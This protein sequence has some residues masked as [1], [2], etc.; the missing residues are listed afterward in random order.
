MKVENN[1]ILITGGASGIGLEFARQF[2]QLGNRVIVTGRNLQK[3][4]N[5]RKNFPQIHTF[6][7]D[8]TLAEDIRILFE[9]VTQRFPELN[10][11][12]NNAGIGRILDLKEQ[13]S[14]F[15]LTEELDTN[16]RA[17]IQM[18][19][20]FLPQ[21]KQQKDAAIINVSSALAFVPFPKV[22]IYSA[23]KAGLHSY[24]LSLRIQLKNTG[25]KVFEVAPPSTQT[26]MLDGL[27]KEI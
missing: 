1:T 23:A 11:L 7:S 5:V 18:I 4:E 17:P 19:N 12:I 16:L 13:Q 10:I 9:Q 26:D 8:V 3:L 14:A 27:T 6:K 25:I 22:P 2:A 15:S 20:Q 21:L 24:S